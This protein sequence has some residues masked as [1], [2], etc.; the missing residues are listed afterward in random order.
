MVTLHH[1][2]ISPVDMGARTKL[3]IK[4]GDV[5]RVHL[6]IEEK[7]KIRLQV[8]EGLVI[9]RKHGNEP[10]GTITV[11]KIA[12]GVGVEK[13]LPLFSPAIDHIDIVRSSKARRS[14]IY[15]VRDKSTKAL[16]RKFKQLKDFVAVSS[17]DLREPEPESEV[18]LEEEEAT[19][20][21]ATE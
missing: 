11:R 15:F 7:G 3:G 8:F 14:K 4:A 20:T 5:V 9:A 10:G 12:S 1:K 18:S 16:S 2:M 21:P 17:V 13:V 19:E 6:K